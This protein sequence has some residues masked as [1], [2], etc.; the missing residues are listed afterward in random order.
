MPLSPLP[1]YADANQLRSCE[2][3]V[4]GEASAPRTV[5]SRRHTRPRTHGWAGAELERSADVV[6][7][8]AWPISIAAAGSLA[9]TDVWLSMR[10]VIVGS[11]DRERAPRAARAEGDVACC[12]SRLGEFRLAGL[13]GLGGRIWRI[14]SVVSEAW[15][16]GRM[17]EMKSH[18]AL[19]AW[20]SG[21]THDLVHPLKARPGDR[22][23]VLSPSFA[24]AGAFPEVHEQAMRRLSEVTEL[25]AVEYLGTGR[26]RCHVHGRHCRGIDTTVEV[27]RCAS[28]RLGHRR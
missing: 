13:G 23:A 7:T 8:S 6:R 10:P 18:A 19:G 26:D 27:G 24:A 3:A 21:M 9:D 28:K 5:K 4:R 1:C 11:T 12:G 25:I 14:P 15:Q 2:T 22:I 16:V 17:M 20:I